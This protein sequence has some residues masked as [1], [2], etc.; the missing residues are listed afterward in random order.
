MCVQLCLGE[1]AQ[2]IWTHLF[3]ET[4]TLLKTDKLNMLVF[5]AKNFLLVPMLP[6]SIFSEHIPAQHVQVLSA[7]VMAKYVYGEYSL[8]S[9]VMPPKKAPKSK[10]LAPK[11][12]CAICSNEVENN[13][14]ATCL[15]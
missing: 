12:C 14:V 7:T 13:K 8:K 9:I 1:T 3:Q 4:Y 10:P 6:R 11:L 15:E 2:Y 5:L